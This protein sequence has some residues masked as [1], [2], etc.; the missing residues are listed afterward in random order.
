MKTTLLSLLAVMM[1]LSMFAV[2]PAG[3]WGFSYSGGYCG[4]DYGRDYNNYSG[5]CYGNSGC[6]DYSG[7]WGWDWNWGWGHSWQPPTNNNDGGCGY[8]P[9]GDPPGF[10]EVPEPSSLALLGGGLATFV[11]WVGI[12]RRKTIG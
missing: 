11:S 3:A 9:P 6:N 4:N 5:D 8:H 10:P 2:L 1:L 7:N 12:R